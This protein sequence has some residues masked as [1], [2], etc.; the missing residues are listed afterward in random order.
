[1]C[2]FLKSNKRR[3]SFRYILWMTPKYPKGGA[4][5]ELIEFIWGSM[6]VRLYEGPIAQK[7]P[8]SINRTYPLIWRVPVNLWTRCPGVPVSRSRCPVVSSPVSRCLLIWILFFRSL[9]LFLSMRWTLHVVCLG[10]WCSSSSWSTA[11][12]SRRLPRSF[13]WPHHTCRITPAVRRQTCEIDW[14]C[15]IA[16]IVIT[17]SCRTN[18]VIF[19][20]LRNY[21]MKEEINCFVIFMIAKYEQFYVI[22][23]RNNASHQILSF[24]TKYIFVQDKRYYLALINTFRPKWE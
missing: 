19:F 16:M 15:S 20:L 17:H 7:I 2:R 14:L 11:R 6:R 4:M 13:P 5:I 22:I 8:L 21:E 1:M 10:S 18:T 9:Y 24:H 12:S 23:R 3:D